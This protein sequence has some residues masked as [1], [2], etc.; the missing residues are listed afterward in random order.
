MSDFGRAFTRIVRR[1][2]GFLDDMGMGGDDRGMEGKA[3]GIPARGTIEY[4][5]HVVRVPENGPGNYGQPA[6]NVDSND[7]NDERL[8][9]M[10][11]AN[12][13]IEDARNSRAV[14]KAEASEAAAGVKDKEPDT[15]EDARAIGRAFKGRLTAKRPTKPIPEDQQVRG[16]VPMTG[17]RG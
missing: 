15:E 10:A 13:Q 11:D 6:R 5:R 1:K 7:A 3:A 17:R 9:D 4:E 8:L 14:A 2:K 16:G 12:R